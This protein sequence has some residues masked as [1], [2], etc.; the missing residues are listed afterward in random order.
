MHLPTA[1]FSGRVPFV[2]LRA[3]TL[4]LRCRFLRSSAASAFAPAS[5][6]SPSARCGSRVARYALEVREEEE[7]RD[8]GPERG[9][10]HDGAEVRRGGF[11]RVEERSRSRRGDAGLDG[12][13]RVA[14][15]ATDE[16]HHLRGGAAEGPVVLVR[17][18]AEAF[19]H[20]AGDDP[21]HELMEVELDV[22]GGVDD[23]GAR[24][25]HHGAKSRK[26]LQALRHLLGDEL[27]EIRHE[28]VKTAVG[29][30]RVEGGAEEG[31]VADA[32]AASDGGDAIVVHL[33]FLGELV[34][35]HGLDDG[36]VGTR[37]GTRVGT[38]AGTL[39]APGGHHLAGR[40]GRRWKTAAPEHIR[41]EVF[42]GEGGG[43]RG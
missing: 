35:H 29:G 17:V 10:A 16:R 23:E 31:A 37:V 20:H 14:E 27:H 28:L 24:H 33:E 22:H 42:L 5:A 30:E 3:A 8:A 9:E 11:G 13:V 19:R 36:T 4:L 34:R 18:R 12:G 15:R 26:V 39:D 38:L 7:T 41:S 43:S 32:A 40:D 6:P 2:R 25:R 21:G 1:S